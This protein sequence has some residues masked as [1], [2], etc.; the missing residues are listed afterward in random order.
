MWYFIVTNCNL[1]KIKSIKL[2]S[3]MSDDF[4]YILNWQCNYNY[5][6]EHH[7]L[8]KIHADVLIVNHSSMVP[9]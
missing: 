9:F 1:I 2:L 6:Y 5:L 8:Y 3:M 4:H 7:Y